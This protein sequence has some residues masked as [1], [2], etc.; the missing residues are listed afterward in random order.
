MIAWHQHDT[1]F[2]VPQAEDAVFASESLIRHG[3]LSN[4]PSMPTYAFSLLTLESFHRL[5]LRAPR[6]S[7]QSFLKAI[8]DSQNDVY[9]PELAAPF[10]KALDV[11][12]AI[13]RLVDQQVAKALHRDSP[14]WQIKNACPPCSYKLI[15]E[16]VLPHDI[17]LSIDG[18]NSLKRFANAG[19]AS[20]NL[21]FTS[22]YFVSR[23]D[24]DGFSK[25][26]GASSRGKKGKGK[27]RTVKRTEGAGE[28]EAAEAEG[29]AEDTQMEL[30][31]A[32]AE[33]GNTASD[34]FVVKN[35]PIG[36]GA[37]EDGH[38]L[39]SCTERWKANA[40]DTQKKAF[41]C[42]E[43]AGVFVCVCRHGHVLAIADMVSSGEL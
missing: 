38:L 12:L 17:L 9:H 40:D 1:A 22:K 7:V 5:R 24:V 11:Y 2:V 42:F 31:D 13:L 27:G 8:C 33:A 28:D 32:G 43:E 23:Q 21:E 30:N 3:L 19:S 20:N 4:S 15:D 6:L 37:D 10:A 16:P 29:H 35:L 36:E 25:K 14:L 34:E 41:N 39:S 26:E 18:G